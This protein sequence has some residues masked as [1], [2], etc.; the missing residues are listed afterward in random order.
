MNDNIPTTPAPWSE[1]LDVFDTHDRRQLRIAK[2]TFGPC[3]AAGFAAIA[4]YSNDLVFNWSIGLLFA[5]G[6]VGC[7]VTSYND[8]GRRSAL[9][10]LLGEGRWSL[11]DGAIG[12]L[13]DSS[14]GD[15]EFKLTTGTAVFTDR[16]IRSLAQA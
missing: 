10:T 2:A 14:R 15:V 16:D 7:A 3:L 12:S 6:F 13:K 8:R 9:R 4:Y 5:A 1:I 11:A